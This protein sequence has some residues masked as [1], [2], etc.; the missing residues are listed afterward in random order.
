MISSTFDDIAE[1][2]TKQYSKDA[3]KELEKQL[4]EFSKKSTNDVVKKLGLPQVLM[5]FSASVAKGNKHE[6]IEEQDV[7]EAN[8]LLKYLVSRDL[9]QEFIKFESIN[10][11][12]PQS[13]K[14]SGKLSE[15]LRISSDMKTKNNLD[16]KITRLTTFLSDQ[17]LSNK[18]INRIEIEMRAAILLVSRLIAIGRS[19]QYMKVNPDDIDLSYDIIRFLIFKLDT[20]KVKI[21]KELYSVDDKKIWRKIPKMIFDQSTHDHLS[22]TAYAQWENELPDS[23]EALKK[24]LN[25]GSRPFI[26]AIFGFSE[27]YGAKNDISKINS[28]DLNYI[29]EDFEKM[30]FGSLSPM[31]IEENGVSIIFTEDG[32]RLLSNISQW[33]TT[34]I[35][36]RLGK[37]EFV[38]NYSST[39]PRQI[40]L[41]LFMSIVERIKSNESKINIKHILKSVMKWTN[42]LKN[43]PTS[44]SYS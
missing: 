20:T 9:V 13:E 39:V 29:L 40:S 21:L 36:N 44:I 16:N 6:I 5:L 15:L 41:L 25:C 37:D 43:L 3:R 1:V 42:Q 2:A 17:K 7:L 19:H 10:L 4:N 18:H 8:S 14:L 26:A 35:V 38:L 28:D 23:F 33:V 32:L 31:I 34:I 22:E 11:G 27:I 12:L 24:H 30:I